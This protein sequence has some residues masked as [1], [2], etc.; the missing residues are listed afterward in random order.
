[1]PQGLSPRHKAPDVRSET[2]LK[3][4]EAFGR[5]SFRKCLLNSDRAEHKP[6][7]IPTLMKTV[8]H[9]VPKR[10]MYVRT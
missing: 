7:H 5:G 6:L 10:W 3:Y 9:E 2:P 4:T 1:M 8:T